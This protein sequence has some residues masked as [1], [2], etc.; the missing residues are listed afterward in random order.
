M[1]GIQ[2]MYIFIGSATPKNDE[3]K[4]FVMKLSPKNSYFSHISSLG[5]KTTM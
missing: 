5:I 1:V 4:K 2:N 3:E